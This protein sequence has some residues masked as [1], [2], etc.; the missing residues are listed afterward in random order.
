MI[1]DARE[2]QDVSQA[3]LAAKISMYREN[4]IRVEKGRVNLTVETLMR[5]S[6]G[7][8]VNITVKFVGASKG[9]L[10][11]IVVRA[12]ELRPGTIGNPIP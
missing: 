12:T 4:L 3:A 6:E 2:R 1:R 10:R 7:L 8:G 11:P 9:K 5:I